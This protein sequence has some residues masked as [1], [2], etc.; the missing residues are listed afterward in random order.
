MS[1]KENPDRK[2]MLIIAAEIPVCH[3]C[4][5]FGNKI[6]IVSNQWGSIH[7]TVVFFVCIYFSYFLKL[8]LQNLSTTFINPIWNMLE[9]LILE[10]CG[11]KY[12][13]RSTVMLCT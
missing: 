9:S 7:L 6:A 2:Q 11:Y 1:T 12:N 3:I 13:K 4:A 5:V 10:I 8:R